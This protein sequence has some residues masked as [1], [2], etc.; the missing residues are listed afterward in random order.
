VPKCILQS[1]IVLAN[2][3]LDPMLQHAD[4]ALPHLATLG[5]P[6]EQYMCIYACLSVVRCASDGQ[7]IHV[8]N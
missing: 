4:I 6:Y 8:F 2:G 7:L 1:S 5:F 3:Q